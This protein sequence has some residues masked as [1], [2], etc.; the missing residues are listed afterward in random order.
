M[1]SSLHPA[2]PLSPLEIHSYDLYLVCFSGGKDSVALVL[3]L[4][5]LGVPPDKIELH[6]QLVD[7]RKSGYFFD[8]PC[9]KSYCRAF[10]KAFGLKLYL[11]WREGGFEGE[12]TR[13]DA[14][15][16]AACF[17]TP[18][19]TVVRV[20]GN[21]PNATCEK[22]PA[23][24][25]PKKGRWCSTRLKSTVMT[26]LIINQERLQGIR[27]A[28]I[29]GERAEESRNRATYTDFEPHD[30]DPRINFFRSKLK[31]RKF[32]ATLTTF[33]LADNPL[34]L[35][36]PSNFEIGF[37]PPSVA[38]VF[39]M[40]QFY[41]KS[42]RSRT[43]RHIDRIRLVHKWTKE[44]VWEIMAR[45]KINPHPAYRLGKGRLSCVLC[46]FGNDD[47][48]A[49]ARA[50]VPEQFKKAAYYERKFDHPIALKGRGVKARPY[51]LEDRAQNGTPFDAITLDLMLE[52]HDEDWEHHY[53]IFIDD[54]KLP[55]GAYGSDNG[56]T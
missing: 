14:P 6:H 51:F 29:S 55:A 35:K 37:H 26:S 4:L 16:G 40:M 54:W 7:G 21:G 50:I 44:Q 42:P 32:T 56:P 47:E 45:H 8:Y 33:L 2:Q 34:Y 5:E 12:L 22:Y 43:N 1:R 52:I 3:A 24:G 53:P 38:E 48:W 10:A 28:V 36:N 18:D 39:Q 13:K 41:K 46:I 25:D 23:I 19:G 9:T 49:S 27:V 15:T 17:E 11:S 31:E 20:G 30:S